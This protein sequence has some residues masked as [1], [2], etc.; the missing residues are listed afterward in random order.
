M[1]PGCTDVYSTMSSIFLNHARYVVLNSCD[2]HYVPLVSARRACRPPP[3]PPLCSAIAGRTADNASS[4]RTRTCARG[5]DP[6]PVRRADNRP[7]ASDERR[8][9]SWPQLWRTC[10][11]P[12]GGTRRG[13]GNRSDTPRPSL[14][15]ADTA[16]VVMATPAH[17]ATQIPSLCLPHEH[18]E[19][20]CLPQPASLW[21][22]S[23]PTFVPRFF[24][25]V[26]RGA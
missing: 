20:T 22:W 1:A 10:S 8:C 4:P 15:A 5:T 13:D 6:L 18:P 23:R 7:Q 14:S 12:V 24:L 16:G 9:L 17:G 21:L 19:A 2:T 11:L 3:P 26:A 25:M